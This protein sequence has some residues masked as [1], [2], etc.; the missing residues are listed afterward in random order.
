MHNCHMA[1]CVGYFLVT[2]ACQVLC[3]ILCSVSIN[4]YTYMYVVK[5]QFFNLFVVFLKYQNSFE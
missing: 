1:R 2:M 4:K 3:C 5:F